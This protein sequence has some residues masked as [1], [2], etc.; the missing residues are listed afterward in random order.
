MAQGDSGKK[1]MPQEENKE[2]AATDA[3]AIRR[4]ADEFNSWLAR[5]EAMDSHEL[6]QYKEQNK[7]T[8]NS[9]KEA[10]I[11]KVSMCVFSKLCLQN[12]Y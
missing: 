6:K 11:Q 1:L 4:Q 3:K 2:I 9:Q 12:T 10:A 5:M 8:F 7:D